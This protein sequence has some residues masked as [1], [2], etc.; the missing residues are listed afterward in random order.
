MTRDNTGPDSERHVV[1]SQRL[2][3]GGRL[4]LI[5]HAL[6]RLRVEASGHPSDSGERGVGGQGQAGG[7]PACGR[8]PGNG[9]S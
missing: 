3:Q 1:P 9:G 7:Q 4:A 6:L 2:R 8:A 5:T